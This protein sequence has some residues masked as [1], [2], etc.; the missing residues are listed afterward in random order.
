MD[1]PTSRRPLNGRTV[2]LFFPPASFSPRFANESLIPMTAE[3][4]GW[5]WS[6]AIESCSPRY[7]VYHV[8]VRYGREQWL[9]K[10]RY[11][12]FLAFHKELLDEFPSL[13]AEG[14]PVVA[15]PPKSW[16]CFGMI[17][18]ESFLCSRQEQ[19]CDFLVSLLG[20][21]NSR[22]LLQCVLVTDFLEL[23]S[24]GSTTS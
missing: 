7:V 10:R 6:D 1:K 22:G 18:D 21:L 3:L 16:A 19:L 8:H 20:N 5:A 17:L 9:L 23:R 14:Q 24:K 13:A 15:F 11:S 2:V 12:H 4:T